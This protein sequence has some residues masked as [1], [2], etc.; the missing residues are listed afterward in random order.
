MSARGG[1]KVLSWAETMHGANTFAS[2]RRVVKK[3]MQPEVKRVWFP[4][5]TAFSMV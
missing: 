4:P 5:A 1:T 3:N 2:F